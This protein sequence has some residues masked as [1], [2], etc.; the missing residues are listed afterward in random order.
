MEWN[1][2]VNVDDKVAYLLTLTEEI[3]DKIETYDWYYLV[4]KAIDM[5]WE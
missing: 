3:I 2:S 5:C 4:K 1:E